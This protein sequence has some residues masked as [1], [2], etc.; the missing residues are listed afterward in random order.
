MWNN[1]FDNPFPVDEYDDARENREYTLDD[2]RVEWSN[3]FSRL[4]E[5]SRRCQSL[6]LKRVR[7]LQQKGEQDEIDAGTVKL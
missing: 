1:F 2:I 7:R 3:E 5:I 4:V 6:Q